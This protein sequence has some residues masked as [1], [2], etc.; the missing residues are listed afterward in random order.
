MI[1]KTVTAAAAVVFTLIA[2]SGC[3]SSGGKFS[4]CRLPTADRFVIEAKIVGQYAF[5]AVI[6]ESYAE[7]TGTY[8]TEPIRYC[9]GE[10]TCDGLTVNI[11]AKTGSLFSLS[12]LF[13]SLFGGEYKDTDSVETSDSYVFNTIIDGQNISVK[14]DK[15][16]GLPTV[17]TVGEYTITVKNIE[18]YRDTTNGSH[19]QDMGDG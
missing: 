16:T 13:S 1:K 17:F 12:E 10:L 8:L 5:D 7:F 6:T 9:S 11:A 2:L 3:F 18:L 15:E 19:T 4:D 14:T